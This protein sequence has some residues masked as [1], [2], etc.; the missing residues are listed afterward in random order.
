MSDPGAGGVQLP[1][2][3]GKR[4]DWIDFKLRF[5]AWCRRKGI[6]ISTAGIKKITSD[7]INCALADYILQAVKERDRLLLAPHDE[8]GKRCVQNMSF[9]LSVSGWTSRVNC[10]ARFL[11]VLR[12]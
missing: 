4:K 2:F 1:Q 6:D 5:R 11:K 12:E 10:G 3:S 9:S 8:D 7:T